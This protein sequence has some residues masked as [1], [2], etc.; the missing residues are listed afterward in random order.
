MTVAAIALPVVAA[1][2]ERVAYN[3]LGAQL[4]AEI[5]RRATGSPIDGFAGTNLFAPLGIERWAWNRD[6]DDRPFGMSALQLRREDLGRIGQLSLAGGVVGGTRLFDSEWA[7]DERRRGGAF[8]LLE[9][10]V[11]EVDVLVNLDGA[12]GLDHELLAAVGGLAGRQVP[13]NGAGSL[14]AALGRRLG[15]DRVAEAWAAL[16]RSAPGLA[17]ART[18]PQAYGHDGSGGQHLW[19]VP[20]VD[21]VAVRVRRFDDRAS[22]PATATAFCELALEALLTL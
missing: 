9:M 8:G 7:V 20:S 22:D 12:E 2:G 18:A 10:L 16:R 15:P 4:V 6:V 5:I 14:F 19:V 3:N 13:I 21:G 1:P 11:P 17:F